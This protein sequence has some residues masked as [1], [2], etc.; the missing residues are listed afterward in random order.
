MSDTHPLRLSVTVPKTTAV[1][2]EVPRTPRECVVRNALDVEYEDGEDL[3]RHLSRVD[4]DWDEI[5]EFAADDELDHFL[6]AWF[7]VP[8]HRRI[9]LIRDSGNYYLGDVLSP[10][11]WRTRMIE[12]DDVR[13]LRLVENITSESG[14][15]GRDGTYLVPFMAGCPPKC[16][17]EFARDPVQLRRVLNYLL[18]RTTADNEAMLVEWLKCAV[19]HGHADEVWL[20]YRARADVPFPDWAREFLTRRGFGY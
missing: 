4:A 6:R 12:R 15:Q 11:H 9:A 14:G 8:P 19:Q 18:D 3:Y 13:M 7:L 16:R 17:N 1:A 2:W 5:V 20:I 10:V